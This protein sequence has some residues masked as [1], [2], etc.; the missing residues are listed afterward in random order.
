MADLYS[1]VYRSFL[2]QL[3]TT[4]GG[5]LLIGGICDEML[6]PA[7]EHRRRQLPHV[8]FA[9]IHDAYELDA[10]LSGYLEALGTDIAVLGASVFVPSTFSR[11]GGIIGSPCQSPASAPPI[12]MLE[13]LPDGFFLWTQPG[14]PG[15][16]FRAD[17][18]TRD[19]V[20]IELRELIGL[21]VAEQAEH[22]RHLLQTRKVSPHLIVCDGSGPDGHC[23]IA[24]ADDLREIVFSST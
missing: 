21:P 1:P 8:S 14:G 24:V 23:W 22:I 4:E 10:H 18:S 13:I 5:L 11:S 17:Q 3:Q 16:A 12:A 20:A 9:D 2:W 7:L 15:V 6:L 19:W